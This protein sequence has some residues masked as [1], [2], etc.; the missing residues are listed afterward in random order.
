[1][2]AGWRPPLAGEVTTEP[3]ALLVDADGS[4]IEPS[5]S[6]EEN[7]AVFAAFAGADVAAVLDRA[8]ELATLA[9]LPDPTAPLAPWGA[10]GAARLRLVVAFEE[11][12]PRVLLV[13]AFPAPSDAFTAWARTATRD[14]LARG[15][16]LVQASEPLLAP[17]AVTLELRAPAP[18]TA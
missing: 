1:V 5:L 14:L 11:A 17:A 15:G 8:A 18:V 16:V 13:D 10:A 7:L 3:S 6:V 4:G 12:R 9:E 2:L